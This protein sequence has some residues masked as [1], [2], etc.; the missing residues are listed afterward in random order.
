MPSSPACSTSSPRSSSSSP[1]RRRP[2]STSGGC[3]SPDQLIAS[4]VVSDGLQAAPAGLALRRVPFRHPRAGD[5]F[6]ERGGLALRANGDGGG[7][8]LRLDRQ[9]PALPPDPRPPDLARRLR[10]AGLRRAVGQVEAAAGP[11]DHEP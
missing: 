2:T 5:P 11:T 8:L 4:A 7:E 9:L 3:S 10:R 1:P 6:R